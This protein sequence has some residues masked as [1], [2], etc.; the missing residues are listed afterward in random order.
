ME[1]TDPAALI[2]T[3]RLRREVDDRR[4]DVTSRVTGTLTLT[5]AGEDRIR[6]VEE[7]RWRQD[8]GVVDVRR[9]LWVVRTDA[10][11]W[12]VRFDDG[13]DFHPWRPGGP[14]VHPCA[15][16]TYRGTVTGSASRWSIT[17]EVTGPAKDYR[18]VTELTP[19]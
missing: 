11:G 17:W 7:G 4:L 16:D 2:G 14:V 5:R 3:W 19:V 9:A 12:W 15:P 8:T 6:W 1:L 10:D 13:R 18:M